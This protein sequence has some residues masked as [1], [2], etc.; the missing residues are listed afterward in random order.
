MKFLHPLL[1]LILS[2]CLGSAKAEETVKRDQTKPPNI[3]L[4]L[5][6]DLGI[7]DVECYGGDLCAI[8]TPNIDKLASSGIRFTDAYVTASV[9]IPSRMAIMTGR[10]PWRFGPPERGGPWGF[11]GLRFPTDTYT[12][13]DMLKSAGHRTGYVGKWHLGTTMKTV[14][15]GVQQSNNVDF[16]QPLLAGPNDFGFDETFILPGSLDMFPY[17]FL[18]DHAWVGDV[19]ATK[20]W[21]AF[22]RQGPAARDFEDHEVLETMYQESESFIA[23]QSADQPFFLFVGLTAPHTPTSPGEKWQNKS[24]VGIYGDFVM[25]VDHAVQRIVESLAKAGLED[26][27]LV[28]FSSDHGPAPYA[29]ENPVATPGQ[30]DDMMKLGHHANGPH[31]GYK[32]SVFEGGLR[33]PLIAKWP[34]GIQRPGRVSDSIVSLTDLMATFAEVAKHDLADSQAPDSLS[35][36]PVF[37]DSTATTSRSS[38]VMQ[39]GGNFVIRQNQWKL[40]LNPGSGATGKYGNQPAEAGAWK[41]AMER[42]GRTPDE[43]EIGRFPFVQLYDLKND[44]GENDNLAEQHPE[45]VAELTELLRETIESGRSTPGAKL[46]NDRPHIRYLPRVP[47]K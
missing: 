4:I 31:R 46:K 47:R 5:A 3:V 24:R 29:G 9:C 36:A 43:T 6:D 41:E 8:D 37:H 34:A 12:L 22:N 40:C 2:L 17:A 27:T 11:L 44:P 25:E 16:T 20:G 7:G 19:D 42:F 18:R 33:V 10:Y 38:V 30:M 35:F 28:V 39:G 13:A 26:N 1:G 21:S 14:N 45:I 23:K 15:G 32:F